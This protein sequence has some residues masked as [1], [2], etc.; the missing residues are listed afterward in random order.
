M[1][2]LLFLSKLVVLIIVEL[3]FDILSGLEG[4]QLRLF[5][6]WSR[7]PDVDDRVEVKLG[8]LA[9]DLALNQIH[10]HFLAVDAH[11]RRVPD[12]GDGLL[13]DARVDLLSRLRPILDHLF[14]E[15]A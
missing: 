3:L 2:H 13:G 5:F 9:S 1:V 12:A 10:V 11:R 14:C 15:L 8:G 6:E 7:E 4:G